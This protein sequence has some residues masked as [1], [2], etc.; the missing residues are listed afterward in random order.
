MA[1]TFRSNET[2]RLL[3]TSEESYSI[4]TA[5]NSNPLMPSVNPIN[6]NLALSSVLFEARRQVNEEMEESEFT[7]EESYFETEESEIRT[8]TIPLHVEPAE[9]NRENHFNPKS[10][11]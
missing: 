2:V 6:I 10:V 11:R 5:G 8:E 9:S 3:L 7:E 1:S 4:V